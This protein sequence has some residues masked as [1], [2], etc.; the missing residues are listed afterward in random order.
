MAD[1]QYRAYISYSH[2]DETWAKWLHAALE[3]YHVPRRLVGTKGRFGEIP[4]RINPVF[5]DREDLSAARD[6][7][8]R[9]TE[10]LGQSES[11]IVICSPAA[12]Q[13]RWVNEEIRQYRSSSEAKRI[14]C[15]IVDGDP[16]AESAERRC[17]PPALFEGAGQQPFEPLAADVREWADGKRLAKLK[18]VAGLLGIRLDELRQRDQQ[19]RRKIRAIAGLGAVAVLALVLTLLYV[20]ISRQHEREMSEQMASF[21]VDLGEK[22]QSET[23]LETLASISAEALKHFSNLNPA[24]L[25]AET[26]KK[27]AL[28]LRQV[29]RID[30]LQGK[31]KEALQAFLQSRDVLSGLSLRN[32]ESKDL[33][34]ELGLAEYYI[35][36]FFVDQG[37]YVQARAAFEKYHEMTGRL[38]DVEPQ[39]TE[40]LMERAYSHNNLA[41]VQLDSGMGVD[42]AALM[43]MQEAVSLMEDVM[44]QVPDKAV[45]ASNYATMLAWAADAQLEAC[46]LDNAIA[47]RQKATRLAENLAQSDPGD[48]DLQRR[49]A[50]AISGVSS[51][52]ASTGQLDL[53]EQNLRQ[54][55][56]IFEQ[57]SAAD[58]SNMLY[59]QQIA[60]RQFRLARLIAASGRL[61]EAKALMSRL[62]ALIG[63]EKGAAEKNEEAILAAMDFHLAYAEID[64]LSGD[65]AAANRQLEKAL[66]L[67]VNHPQHKDANA[68]LEILREM[69]FQW[70]EINGWQGLEKFPAVPESRPI[71]DEEMRSCEDALNAARTYVMEGN[72]ADAAAPVHYLQERRY[73]APAFIRF[74]KKYGLC[75][76]A[77]APS[78]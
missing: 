63:A 21:I 28:T 30:Q 31:P 76:P 72:L 50:Y 32:P 78:G 41:A 40:W 20:Q 66:G 18:L 42:E 12:A 62:D 8:Q 25:T 60:Y 27:V 2:Q 35:G 64:Y 67:L 19:R 68:E 9:I 61:E 4:P 34:Y 73:A 36:N 55:I 22:L 26:G 71:A 59:S 37:N 70:W 52:Q 58:P 48:N 33:M 11:L 5:R 47:L 49:Y 77:P 3:S 1:F 14:Y 38:L 24:R 13:S 54:V 74:C 29:G 23:D 44:Q 51:L 57:L 6:L 16:G 39:N 7:S 46:N 65:K 56:A 69:R 15:L 53:A 45:Y 75:N 17:F 43:H 10:A